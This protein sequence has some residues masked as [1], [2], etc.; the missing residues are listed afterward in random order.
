VPFSPFLECQ[1]KLIF[2]DLDFPRIVEQLTVAP[3]MMRGSLFLGTLPWQLQRGP[4][5]II[6]YRR[7]MIDAFFFQKEKHFESLQFD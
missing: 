1:R 5:F 6:S 3:E 2:D 7:N 4:T